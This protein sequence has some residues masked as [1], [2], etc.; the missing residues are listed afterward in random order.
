MMNVIAA[1]NGMLRDNVLSMLSK[2]CDAVKKAFEYLDNARNEKSRKAAAKE[3]SEAEDTVRNACRKGD[4]CDLLDSV[5]K[6]RKARSKSCANAVIAICA[7]MFAGG[8][9][10]IDVYTTKQW[11]G[12]YSDADQAAKALHGVKLGRKESV[13]LLSSQ[14]L[15]RILTTD[16]E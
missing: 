8:C 15:E 7:F 13:W 12:R 2:L 16:K 14:T 6:L 10:T 3:K 11:E 5:G 4:L 1:L 9:T